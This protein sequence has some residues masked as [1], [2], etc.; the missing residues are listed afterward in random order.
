MNVDNQGAVTPSETP[1]KAGGNGSWPQFEPG[2]ESLTIEHG[3]Y[4]PAR[5]A[6]RAVVVHESLL[7]VAPWLSE[8]HY[9]PSVDRYLK[10]TAREQLAHE[11]LIDRGAT[12]KGF[13]RLLETATAASRLAWFMADALGLTPTGHAR[14]K[15]LIADAV[16]AEVSLGDLAAEGARVRAA[17]AAASIDATAEEESS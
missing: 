3:A 2:H 11:A 7:K 10:A 8:E 1:K 15:V 16:E 4:T 17:R 13:T 6:E 9:A 12:G 5:I 14:M